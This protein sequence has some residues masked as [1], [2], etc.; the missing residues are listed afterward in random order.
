M[1]KTKPAPAK[2]PL[3]AAVVTVAQPPER[4]LPR[5]PDSVK[6][7]SPDGSEIRVILPDGRT[8]I[9]T[10]DAR[11]LPRAFYKAAAASGCVATSQ[12]APK[13]MLAPE[14]GVEDDPEARA[15]LIRETILAAL[16]SSEDDPAFEGAFTQAGLPNVNWL[17]AQ[18]NF[19]V[20]RSERDQIWGEMQ[21]AAETGDTSTSTGDVE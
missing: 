13:D 2:K 19:A 11:E 12:P 15:E 1:S 7:F 3:A 14:A 4:P 20:E 21:A 8:A 17:S 10:E 6:W 16:N 5:M 9:V 18:V